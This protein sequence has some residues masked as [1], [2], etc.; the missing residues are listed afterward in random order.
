MVWLPWRAHSFGAFDTASA[1]LLHAPPGG[2]LLN[3]ASKMFDNASAPPMAPAGADLSALAPSRRPCT[4]WR[5]RSLARGLAVAWR[6]SGSRPIPHEVDCMEPLVLLLYYLSSFAGFAMV[7]GGIILIYKQKIYIDARSNDITSVDTPLGKFRTNVPALVL[8][9][10]GF[11]PLIFPIVELRNY[12]KQTKITG[13]VLSNVIPVQVYAAVRLDAV[14]G[15]GNFDLSVP[16][17]V[18]TYKILY[19]AYGASGTVVL[20]EVANLNQA[21]DGRVILP[22]KQIQLPDVARYE[23]RIEV[24]PPEFERG[25]NR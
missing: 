10:L 2:G 1:H 9:A 8:F 24:L 16:A 6:T 3:H 13:S 25:G 22:P 19:V 15:D 18:G 21:K 14:S 7:I 12:C 20:D 5:R 4:A 11:V 17:L 23:G